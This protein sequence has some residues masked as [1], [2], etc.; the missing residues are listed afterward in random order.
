MVMEEIINRGQADSQ[1]QQAAFQLGTQI[2]LQGKKLSSTTHL[3]LCY[4]AF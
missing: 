1:A 3:D 2:T 4:M